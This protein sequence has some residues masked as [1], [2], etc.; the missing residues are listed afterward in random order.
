MSEQNTRI[1]PQRIQ[2]LNDKKIDTTK[3]FVLY[4][5]QSSQRTQDNHALGYA[6]QLANQLNKPLL[7][8]FGLTPNFPEANRRHYQFMLEGLVDVKEELEK[9][10]IQFL[11]MLTDVDKGVISLSFRACAVVVDRG[12]LRIQ[13]RWYHNV[14]QSIS[15][16]LIQ[17]ESDVLVPIEVTSD[18]QEY[19]AATI[20]RKITKHFDEFRQGITLSSVNKE[21]LSIILGGPLLD[22]S[23][24]DEVLN[25]LPID[26][27]VEPVTS[28]KGGMKE[29]NYHLE[30][31]ITE[32]LK[33]YKESRNDPG[34]NGLSMMSMYLHYGQISPVTLYNKVVQY[35]DYPENVATFI[36]EVIVRRELSMN[37]VNYN[38]DYDN[39]NGL[40]QWAKISLDKHR[41]DRRPVV[42]TQD[43]L[44][45]SK[46][47]DPYWNAA[48]KELV[49]TGKMHGYMRMYW[50]KKVIE[51]S[52]TPENAFQWLITIN[53]KYSL[54]G[55]DPN[56]FVGV[57]WCFGLHDRPWKERPIFGMIRY[58][59]DKGLERKFDMKRYVE[60]IDELVL[61]NQKESH[62][63]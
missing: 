23:N 39:Y 42:Y 21:S 59:N 50:G 5:M 40:P 60:K 51:W 7:V 16:Q 11:V 49:V 22:I 10:K 57:G 44:E 6:I 35:V 24:L 19:A 54:D 56:G 26:Q 8:Y 34:L 13:K 37:F 25:Q 43:E 18:K 62:G 1:H 4:W 55:R 36:E 53:N 14:S 3:E 38:D 31:F 15:C 30:I 46:T 12:Y 61:G 45:F 47:H 29:A 63:L 41:D 48:Q 17:V 33:N 27:S 58:M 9:H 28:L 32:K 2:L 52:E 20:R